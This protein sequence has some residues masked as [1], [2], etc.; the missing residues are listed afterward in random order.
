MGAAGEA[1]RAPDRPEGPCRAAVPEQQQEDVGAVLDEPALP[2]R[3][4]RDA[5]RGVGQEA[6][7]RA[8]AARQG[9]ERVR[10][11]RGGG[12]GG[13]GGRVGGRGRQAPDDEL[14]GSPAQRVGRGGERAVSCSACVCCVTVIVLLSSVSCFPAA[15]Q[16]VE[17]KDQGFQG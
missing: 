15:V 14:L 6:R 17:K 8:L 16:V 9:P 1:E 13:G 11:G 5:V 4:R 3:G 7:Q 12:A 2:P 10:G